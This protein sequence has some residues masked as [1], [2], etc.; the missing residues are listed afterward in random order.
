MLQR[1]QSGRVWE[2][3]GSR[4]PIP[5]PPACTH[6][7]IPSTSACPYAQQAT[8]WTTQGLVPRA[9]PTEGVTWVPRRLLERS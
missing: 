3:T 8:V 7:A 6:T 9:G 5:L 2:A 1:K 4:A